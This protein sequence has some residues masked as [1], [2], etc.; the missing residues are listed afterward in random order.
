[1][2]CDYLWPIPT[3]LKLSGT[4]LYQFTVFVALTLR[5]RTPVY[6]RND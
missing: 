6:S 3:Y 5:N 2:A 1:M 4:Y